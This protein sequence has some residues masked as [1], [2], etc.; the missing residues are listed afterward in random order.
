MRYTIIDN[1]G[2]HKGEQTLTDAMADR[3][4]RRGY[5]LIPAAQVASVKVTFGPVR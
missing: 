3:M 1:H 5:H 2:H 4:E